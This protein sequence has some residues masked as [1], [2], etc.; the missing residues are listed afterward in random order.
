M[1]KFPRYPGNTRLRSTRPFSELAKT[2]VGPFFTG[3]SVEPLFDEPQQTRRTSLGQKPPSKDCERGF[4]RMVAALTL[5][6]FREPLIH[7]L[8][9]LFTVE[10]RD[11]EPGTCF[12]RALSVS[13]LC[14][15]VLPIGPVR[16]AP[17]T[18]DLCEP[19]LHH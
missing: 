4:D 6:Q 14:T 18:R 5:R 17:Q 16:Q 19:G 1:E 7:L 11:A 13:G 9:E 3:V 12:G 2:R 10:S 15:A 8:K